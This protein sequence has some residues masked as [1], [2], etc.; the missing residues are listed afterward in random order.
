MGV[1]CHHCSFS[2]SSGRDTPP[3][4]SLLSFMAQKSASSK[5]SSLIDLLRT[6]ESGHIGHKPRW[7]AQQPL[8]WE[9]SG[10]APSA[11]AQRVWHCLRIGGGAC[12]D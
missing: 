4:P 7:L 9:G 10:R 8:L 6:L 5:K 2:P 3:L 12:Q 1:P 11:G